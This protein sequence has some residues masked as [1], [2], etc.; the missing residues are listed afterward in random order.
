MIFMN[1]YEVTYLL[2]QNLDQNE[3]DNRDFYDSTIK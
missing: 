2:H 1:L 3:R